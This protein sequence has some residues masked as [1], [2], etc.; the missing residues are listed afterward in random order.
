VFTTVAKGFSPPSI[1]ELLP[2]TS[3]IST[4][5]EAETGTNYEAGVRLSPFTS[6]LYIQLS[7]YYFRLNNTLVQRRDNTGADFFINA[8]N[9]K[10]KGVDIS[11]SYNAGL[12]IEGTSSISLRGAYTY[13]YYRYGSF[14]RDTI[15]LSGKKLPS[16][17]ANTISLLADVDV[18]SLYANASYYYASQIFLNDVNTASAKGYHLLGLRLGWKKTFKQK[19]MVN[20]YAGADNLLDEVYSL[21]NDINDARGRYF[22]TAAPRNYY[23]GVALQLRK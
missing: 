3:V 8:G 1:S 12:N 2:S 10:Q 14:T 22:N 7:G 23:G 19:L 16:V 17:P 5:L 9:T 21:G 11:V 20:I 4:S 6:L 18:K 15:N 13:A